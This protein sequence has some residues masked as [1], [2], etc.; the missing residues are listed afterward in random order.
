MKK[1][2]FILTAAIV[3]LAFQSKAQLGIH[4]GYNFAKITGMDI[5]SGVDNKFLAN[6]SGGLF[7]EKDLIPLLDLRLGLMYSPKGQYLSEGDLSHKLVLNYLE[8]P[9]MAKVKFGP[10]YAIG[11]VYGGYTLNG[12]SIVDMAGVKVEE[13]IDFANDE[14]K[15]FDYGL[16]FGLGVQTGIKIVKIFAQAD[17]SMGLQNLN[18]GEGDEMKNSVIGVSA[19]VILGF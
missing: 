14:I 5:P 17:Y 13:D 11:G 6:P 9:V 18:D 4:V 7:I 8:I 10:V 3:M 2:T 15:R 12:K 19:G 16:K 1:I